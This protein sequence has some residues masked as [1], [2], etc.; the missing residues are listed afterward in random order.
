MMNTDLNLLKL[1]KEAIGKY[2]MLDCTSVL[3]G[4]SGGKDSC[5]LLC[6]LNSV[7][8]E[9]GFSLYACHV[10]HGIRAGEADRDE[11]FCREFCDTLGVPLFVKKFDIPTLCAESGKGTE[12]CAREHRYRAFAEICEQ[13][14]IERIATAHHANDNAETVLFNLSRGSALKGACGIPPMRDNIIRPLILCTRDDITDYIKAYQLSYVTDSTNTDVTYSRNR[15]RA[16]VIPELC[17]VNDRAVYHISRF[18]QSV[19]TDSEYL[20]MVARENVTDEVGVL[21]GLHSAL[22]SRV[23]R[24]LY[25]NVCDATL[26]NKHIDDVISLVKN[27]ENTGSVSLPGEIRCIK[28]RGRILFCKKEE[29]K[30]FSIKLKLGENKAEGYDFLIVVSE[31]KL[32][33]EILED[34]LNIY[35]KSIY[36]SIASDKLNKVTVRSRMAGDAYRTGGITKKVKKMMQDDKLTLSQKRATP[37]FC[38]E[39]GPFWL[40]GHKMRDG[41]YCDGLNIYYFRGE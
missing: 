30:G 3:V 32:S 25:L 13:N 33:D 36:G 14:G 7:K 20:D 22:L 12:E 39:E 15:L 18:S 27:G 35:K 1:A 38:D 23:I 10:N 6:F 8:E 34:Y 40:P 26:E 5:A 16:A 11:A 4:F 19:R 29:K 24:I 37:V 31:E 28:D 9:Y 17:A 2:N 21:C 41:M